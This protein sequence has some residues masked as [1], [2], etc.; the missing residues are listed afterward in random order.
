[1]AKSPSTTREYRDLFRRLELALDA[2]Q[3]GVWEHNLARDELLWDAQMHRIYRTGRTER[4]VSADAWQNA[5]HPDDMLRANADFDKAIASHGHYDSQFRIVLPG[6]EV[7]HL[8]SRG[9][10]YL[11][12]EGEPSVIGAEWDVTDD[13]VLH[14]ALQSQKVQ[15]E[16]R[17]REL[18]DSYAEIEHAAQHDYLTGLPNRNFFDA[19]LR[20]LQADGRYRSLAV[21]H[22]D[23]DRFKQ[24][25]DSHGHGAGDHVLRVASSRIIG[26]APA[27]AVAAR[28]GGDEFV[29][30]LT[31]FAT[32]QELEQIARRMQK[33]LGEPITFG[34]DILRSG[35][36]IGIGYTLDARPG[37]NLL[38]ESDV[39]L[40]QAKR[41]GR[42]RI[43]FFD[44]ALKDE[45]LA[46][47]TLAAELQG[48]LERREVVPHYQVQI[49]ART[50]AITGLE[51]LV[52]WNHPT[53]GLLSPFEFLPIA[54][55][56]GL[57]NSIDATVLD[58]VLEDRERWQTEGFSVPRIAVNVSATRLHDAELLAE[59]ERRRAD[60]HGIAFELVETIFLDESSDE[61]LDRIRA[62]RTLGIDI[63][64]D[65]FGSGHA[66]LLGLVKI[67]PD[68][69]KI[70]RN[71]VKDVVVSVEQRRILKSIIQIAQ[72]LKVG[73]IAE[74]IETK[75][76][77]E[78]L[79][80][81]GC[82]LFQGYHF[83]RPEP[84][85]MVARRLSPQQTDTEKS[86]GRR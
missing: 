43:A 26:A 16:E 78:A 36:S 74:G 8:R 15:L 34:N 23:L 5:I 60:F 50:G 22:L 52:R 12:D 4:R 61:I 65:D 66:S 62:L 33:A 24:I 7:R 38:T 42:N 9:H 17:A 35:V 77:A 44:P 40:Y 47:R 6:G 13:V 64:I 27:N 83:G 39:A 71:L 11:T 46:R 29:I 19:R 79:R 82:D 49:D 86:A 72:A 53:R 45:L 28:T 69:L 48:G 80:R 37:A 54:Q 75:Q 51:A 59:L 30:V 10:Y 1:M 18:A 67:R 84:A 20:A 68:R 81:L 56:A 14:H 25:N 41:L 70:D 63:E 76:H 57:A 31:D 32:T 2:S 21:L 85:E 55:E 73:V 3:M 58:R